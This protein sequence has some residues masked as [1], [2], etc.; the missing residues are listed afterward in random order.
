M[1]YA[2]AGSVALASGGI[3]DMNFD[4]SP[5]CVADL[6]MFDGTQQGYRY[7]DFDGG[8]E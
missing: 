3:V 8:G 1:T 7:L 5:E 2:S 6:V 4:A